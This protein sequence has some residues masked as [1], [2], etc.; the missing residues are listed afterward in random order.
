MPLRQ[1]GFSLLEVLVAFSILALSMGVLMQIFSTG[2]RSTELSRDY[3]LATSLSQSV[4]ARAGA[5][6]PLQEGVQ[7]GTHADKF[8]WTLSMRP[9]DE[10]VQLGAGAATKQVTG[11]KLMEV[12]VRVEWGGSHGAAARFI[13]FDTVRVFG[14]A[15]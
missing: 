12:T 15:P 7:Q 8:R 3:A 6:I 10:S 2:L 13:S 4:L 1:S 5:D 14:V 9:M 11:V